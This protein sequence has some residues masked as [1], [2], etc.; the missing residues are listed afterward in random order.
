MNWVSSKVR[1]PYNRTPVLVLRG[2]SSTQDNLFF[3]EN[4]VYFNGKNFYKVYFE[5]IED[6]DGKRIFEAIDRNLD[7]VQFWI[8]IH[9]IVKPGES[10]PKRMLIDIETG[11]AIQL[12]YGHEYTKI[13]LPQELEQFLK[14]NPQ[15][16]ML[17]EENMEKLLKDQE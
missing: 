6:R 16:T 13:V 9:D 3:D 12:L 11:E 14:N 17:E 1:L 4:H 7:D 2:E 10:W 15:I 5:W 8:S